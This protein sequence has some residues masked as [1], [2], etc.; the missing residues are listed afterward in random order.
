MTLAMFYLR[1]KQLFDFLLKTLEEECEKTDSLI[2][3]PVLLILS[4]LYPSHNEAINEK[5]CGKMGVGF[6]DFWVVGEGA[7]AVYKCVY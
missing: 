5:V 7:R 2:L 6:C 4:R 1:F 3:H